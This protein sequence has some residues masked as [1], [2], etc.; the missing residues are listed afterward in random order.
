[1]ESVYLYYYSKILANGFHHHGYHEISAAT[2]MQYYYDWNCTKGSWSKRGN[3][4]K[5]IGPISRTEADEMI[6][7]EMEVA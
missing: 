5:I 2:Y 4:E 3:Y 1:M 6:A 7:A